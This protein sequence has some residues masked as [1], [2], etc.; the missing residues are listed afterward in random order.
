MYIQR[1]DK[2]A[3]EIN[4]KKRLYYITLKANPVRNYNC[5]SYIS[6]Y[7]LYIIFAYRPMSFLP[8]PDQ[9]E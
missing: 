1:R 6:V 2:H 7:V 8:S 9:A 3:E 4:I 5:Y